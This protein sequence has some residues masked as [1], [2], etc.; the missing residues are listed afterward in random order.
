MKMKRK[1]KNL[2][3]EKDESLKSTEYCNI[4]LLER[5]KRDIE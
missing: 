4:V 3:Q 5:H 1:R 2:I